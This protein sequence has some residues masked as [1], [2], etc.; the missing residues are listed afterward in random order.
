MT[1]PIEGLSNHKEGSGVIY[2]DY[3]WIA[4]T[5]HTPTSPTKNQEFWNARL[6]PLCILEVMQKKK[7]SV[8]ILT[9]DTFLHYFL[10]QMTRNSYC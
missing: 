6:P 9:V 10:N 1:H 8:Q 3:T 2:S 5:Q 7:Y 4:P